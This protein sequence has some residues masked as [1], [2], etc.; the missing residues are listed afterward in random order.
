MLATAE[1]SRLAPRFASQPVV[2]ASST[3]AALAFLLL[4]SLTGNGPSPHEWLG[5]PDDALRLVEVRELLEGAPWFDVT[6]RRVGAPEPLLSHWSRLVD[7]PLAALIALFRPALGQDLGELVMRLLWPIAL[8]SILC[9]VVGREAY[10]LAG[11][12]AVAAVALLAATSVGATSQFRPGRIDHHNIQIL[13]AVAGLLLLV[14]SLDNH[15]LGWCAGGLIGLGL[16]VGYEAIAL[17]VPAVLLAALV[18]LAQPARRVTALP[19]AAAAT[20]T[21]IA[22]GL[23]TIPP[24]GWLTSRCDS[25]SVNLI[26]LAAS[27]TFGMWAAER[28]GHSVGARLAILA[29]A[30]LAGASAFAALEPACLG[31][32]FGQVE[33]A[34]KPIWLDHVLEAKSLLWF[35]RHEP[36]FTLAQFGFLLAGA[37]AQVV[38]W[39]R[40]RDAGRTLAMSI[41]LLAVALGCWQIKLVAYAS[42]LALLPL[43]C[44]SARLSGTAGVASPWVRAAALVLLNQATLEAAFSGAAG[45]LPSVPPQGAAQLAAA[46]P[47]GPCFRSQSVRV[48]AALRPGLV[49]ADLDLG[50]YIV[51]LTPHR[52]VAAPYHRLG[53]GILANHAIL[54]AEPDRA[55]TTMRALSVD[56]IALC[57]LAAAPGAQATP[58]LRQALLD[59]RPVGFLEPVAGAAPSAIRTW[60][61]RTP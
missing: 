57:K 38:L 54:E 16:A 8:F 9:A 24:A 51:A 15:R 45:I 28:V 42:W 3:A 41:V 7:L 19:A 56:Y 27:G 6:L 14:R 2:V 40:S 33:P 58:T 52:V 43:A 34:L 61:R 46:D 37:A 22:A 44:F 47:R 11:P 48:L 10:R 32:P 23:L 13:C 26:V 50:P 21:L 1:R 5:D 29:G 53:Q 60:R 20:G 12:L 55:E 36:A 30:G 25:L 18:A 4:A 17:V 59:N 35:L 49:A 39:R 31:G